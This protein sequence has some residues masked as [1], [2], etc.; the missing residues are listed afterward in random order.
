MITEHDPSSPS[1]PVRACV[2]D[3]PH[4]GHVRTTGSWCPGLDEDQEPTPEQTARAR[5]SSWRRL[6]TISARD[7]R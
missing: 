2:L 1:R 4:P 5:W 6:R 3:D 7:E